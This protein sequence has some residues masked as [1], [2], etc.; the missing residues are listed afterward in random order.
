MRLRPAFVEEKHDAGASHASSPAA[1]HP[2]GRVDTG[3]RHDSDV[4]VSQSFDRGRRSDPKAL[5]LSGDQ[6]MPWG[7]YVAPSNGLLRSLI[8]PPAPREPAGLVR[9]G[10]A[11]R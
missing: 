2:H 1:C 4:V 10:C 9:Q 3:A 11:P 6:W 8:G 5:E 7:A